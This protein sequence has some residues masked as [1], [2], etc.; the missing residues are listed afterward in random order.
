MF[1]HAPPS[2]V[3]PAVVVGL[4]A[5]AALPRAAAAQEEKSVADGIA[6][7][8]L[9]DGWRLA[10]GA[11]IAGIAVRLAPGWHTYWRDPGEVGMPPSFDWSASGNLAEVAMDWPTPKLF[12]TFGSRSIGYQDAVVLPVR[13]TPRDPARPVDV[14]LNLRLGVCAEV[15]VPDQVELATRFDLVPAD[16]RPAPIRAAFA[17]RP[18][19]AAEAGV[20]DVDCDLGVGPDGPEMTATVRFD[21][22]PAPDQVAVIETNQP[23][24]WIGMPEARVVGHSLVARAPI[25]SK[26]GS[27]ERRGLRLTLIGAE[28]AI[29]IKGCDD[30]GPARQASA[31]R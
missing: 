10:D 16:P 15:C 18:R 21:R 20:A 2:L 28:E 12:D 17:D 30:P 14:V 6:S 19:S 1:G 24:L 4:L 29:D 22:A 25:E 23:G 5:L 3:L 9:I 26:S 31:E 11:V 8:S 7:V 27:I 13:L